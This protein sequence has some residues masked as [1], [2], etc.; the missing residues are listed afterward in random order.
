MDGAELA[1][2]AATPPM[3]AP[4]AMAIHWFK[5]RVT[6]RNAGP[7]S[8]P[9]GLQWGSAPADSLA[10]AQPVALIGSYAVPAGAASNHVT[11][12]VLGAD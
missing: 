8:H 2:L 6:V 11:L 4:P 9:K 3:T 7:F 12:G 10:A 1:L 5:K